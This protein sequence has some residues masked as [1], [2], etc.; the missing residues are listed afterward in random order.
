[1]KG[2]LDRAGAFQ[3]IRAAGNCYQRWCTR[4]RNR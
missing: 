1:M 4:S 2:H 3:V